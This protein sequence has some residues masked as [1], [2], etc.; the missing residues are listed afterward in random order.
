MSAHTPGPWVVKR[1]TQKAYPLAIHGGDFDLALAECVE[2][3]RLIAAAPEL[4]V[5]LTRAAEFLAAN[6]T[7]ADMPDI[8]PACRAALA[9]AGV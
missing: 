8:L 4:L 6:Y 2:N 5:A 9:K 1:S 7:D 3:A